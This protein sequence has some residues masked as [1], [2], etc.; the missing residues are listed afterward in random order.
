MTIST[1]SVCVCVRARGGGGSQSV[2]P[3]HHPQGP[4]PTPPRSS[5][6]R[7]QTSVICSP[8]VGK[9]DS[10]CVAHVSAFYARTR[11]RTN[12]KARSPLVEAQSQKGSPRLP[13]GFHVAHSR[14]PSAIH[15]R[16]DRAHTHPP[17]APPSAPRRRGL[18]KLLD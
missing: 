12:P 7:S 8:I 13:M 15:D 4:A 1:L 11:L 16:D 5:G 6:L 9:G 14:R 18:L 3:P 17:P 2:T 10:S